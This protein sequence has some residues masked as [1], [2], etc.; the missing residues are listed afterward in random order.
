MARKA[1]PDPR[2]LGELLPILVAGRGWR[3]RMALGRL[4]ERWAEVVGERVAARSEPVRLARG[5]LTVRAQGN[6]WAAELTLL[7]SVIASSADRFLSGAG[8]RD[9]RVVGGP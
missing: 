7:A 6:A 2:P 9:V 5:V 3:E 8:I 4:R 1:Q